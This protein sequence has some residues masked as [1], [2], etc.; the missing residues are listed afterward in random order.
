M[1]VVLLEKHATNPEAQIRAISAFIEKWSP[2]GKSFKLGERAGAQPHF[3]ELC[4][5]L[6]IEKPDDPE[7]YC[8]E[9]GFRKA[10]NTRGFADVWKRG[11]FGWEYKAPKADLSA[12]LQQLVQYALPLDNPPLLIVSDR[13]RFEIHT[14]FTGHPSEVTTVQLAELRDPKAQGILRSIFLDPYRFKPRRSNRDITEEAAGAFAEIAE[15]M[16]LRGVDPRHA[17]HF[18]TQCVFCLFAEDTG[19]LRDNVFKRLLQRQVS[20]AAMRKCLADLFAVMKSGGNFGVDDID[21]FNGGLFNEIDVPDLDVSDVSS[22]RTAA[23]L[24]WRAI[25]PSILGTLFERGLDPS[26]RV[27]LGAHYTDPHTILRLVEPTVKR[28]LLTEW[29]KA[30][31]EITQ[32]VGQRDF[33]RVRAKGIPSKSPKL[34]ARYARIRTDANAAD[35]G[36][37][38][39]FSQFLEKLRMFTVLDPACGSGNFLYVALKCLKDIEH[40]VNIEAEELGLQRQLPVTGPQNVLGLEVNSF[41]AELAR[42]TVWIGELQWL[43]EH[44]Y[45]LSCRPVLRSLQHIENRDALLDDTGQEAEWPRASVVVGNPPFLGD[46][47]MRAE[48]GPVYTTTLRARY[49]GRVP[50]GADLVCYWFEK[51]R[52]AIERDGLGAAG[53]VATN[54][55][56]GGKN[57]QVLD[58]VARTTR[59]FE[60]WGDQPWV[61][62]GAAVRVSLVTFG[63]S[64]QSARLNGQEVDRIHSDLTAMGIGGAGVD[65]AAAMPIN[66]SGVSFIGT[67]KGGPFEVPGDLARKWVALPNANS[68]PSHEV[69][70]PWVNGLDI[71][72]RPNDYW[73]I[74]FGSLTRVQAALYEQPWEYCEKHVRPTRTG[75]R[76]KGAEQHWWL[77]QRTRPEL[78]AAVKPLTRYIATARVAKYRIFTWQP[79]AVV[80]DSQVVAIAREDD[81][82]FGI[83]Q[84]RFHELWSLR[85]GTSL[86]DRPRYTP[87]S[88]FETFPF[89]ASLSPAETANQR[90]IAMKD[91][92]RIPSNVP[93][94]RVQLTGR[95]ASVAKRLHDVRDAWLNPPEWTVIVSPAL[96]GKYPSRLVAKAEFK[97]ELSARTLTALYNARPRWLKNLHEELDQAVAAAYGWDDY[98]PAMSDDQVLSRLLVLNRMPPASQPKLL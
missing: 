26:K 48:L 9:R 24:N 14:H 93:R 46:K 78:K 40:L 10:T 32:L 82:T 94:S 57:R 58:A 45:P 20:P 64:H 60:A 62:E 13:L 71:V 80:P 15:R 21:W 42:V 5:V 54:S 47:K 1:S 34:S 74:D 27:Q 61:N 33:L 19:L 37:Q 16:R 8:F 11:H 66:P 50:G 25:D 23:D 59:I 72:R 52:S 69:L 87:T 3:L 6:G 22:L 79:R 36:A 53:L 83:L 35:A 28:P 39:L 18:L 63:S 70:F 44:G 4:E 56:R 98:T 12:A 73:I 96:D 84:S 85:L 75:N 2:G 97:E 67:Q 90:T 41:A 7:N 86:E 88:C 49:E 81:C 30:K 91:G 17:A 29:E 65:L 38:A 95:I 77:L 51:A 31:S 68:R 92:A 89:P 55:I 43:W 76:E